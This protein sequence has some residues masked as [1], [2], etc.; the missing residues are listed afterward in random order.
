MVVVY[1]DVGLV[2]VVIVGGSESFFQC[3]LWVWCVVDGGFEFYIQ[4]LFSLFLGQNLDM[5]DVVDVLVRLLQILCDEQDVFVVES[6][7]KVLVVEIV[8][9]FEIVFLF[10]QD[11]DVFVCLLCQQVVCWLKIVSGLV[12]VV[13]M[14]IEVDGVVF[15]FVVLD[16]FVWGVKC[17][18]IMCVYVLVG[19]DLMLLGIVLVWVIQ[20]V[21][22]KLVLMLGD[23]FVIELMEVYVVQ[24]IVCLCMVGLVESCINLF[25]GVLVCG[26][27]IGVFGVILVCCVFYEF[28]WYFGNVFCVIVVVGGIGLVMVLGLVG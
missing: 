28:Q 2:L 10:G 22:V 12:S 11:W 14:V 20:Q 15:C 24:V 19:G 13:V 21:L 6:Y 16:R 17:V 3:L 25:G 8:L 23:L 9:C 7:C 26:Y 27:L 18:V 5:V 4:F 1:V